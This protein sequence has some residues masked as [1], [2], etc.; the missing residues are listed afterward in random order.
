MGRIIMAEVHLRDVC[1]PATPGDCAPLICIPGASE[2]EALVS[3]HGI[4]FAELSE[5][6]PGDILQ[7]PPEATGGW[8]SQETREVPEAPEPVGLVCSL[9]PDRPWDES[10]CREVT[11]LDEAAV[12]LIRDAVASSW[13]NAKNRM[14]GG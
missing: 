1:D 14:G 3:D 7:D 6:I 13:D 8:G 11:G 12:L 2:I 10:F 5:E 4:E 9:E